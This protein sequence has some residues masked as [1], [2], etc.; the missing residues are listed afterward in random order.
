MV[1][2][3]RLYG[4]STVKECLDDPLIN[5]YLNTVIFDEIIPT[6]G[7]EEEDI[8]FGKAVLE[9]FSNPFVKHQLLSIALNSVSKFKARV[10]PTILEYRE[11]NGYLPKCLT[12][13]LAALIAFY[14][15]DETNDGEEIMSFMKTASVED[16]L[17][18]EQYWGED[19]S[20]MKDEVE[21]YYGSIQKNG[22]GKTIET[23]L[24]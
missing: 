3:A 9:R 11:K 21:K 4:L 12:F 14:R 2:A 15:T 7:H 16:I 5:R 13:S 10:L 23:L 22:V 8:P 18:K 19:L 20:F 6:L 1:L 17:K 24:G